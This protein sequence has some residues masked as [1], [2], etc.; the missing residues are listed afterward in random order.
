MGAEEKECVDSASRACSKLASY[1]EIIKK[2]TTE[3]KALAMLTSAHSN[4]K[5]EIKEAVGRLERLANKIERDDSHS[6]VRAGIEMMRKHISKSN[7]PLKEM[8]RN[9]E[10]QTESENSRKKESIKEKAI[11][12]AERALQTGAEEELFREI[13][14]NKW[15]TEAY[16]GCPLITGRP[17]IWKKTWI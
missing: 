8:P 15:P 6:E 1:Q 9:A 12:K 17:A 2:A 10:T 16:S 14:L 5:K 7:C 4:T 11:E 3:I 13:A